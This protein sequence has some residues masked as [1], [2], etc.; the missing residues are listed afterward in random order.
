V[1]FI[2]R[3]GRNKGKERSKSKKER[4]TLLFFSNHINR[5]S[6][7]LF[8]TASHIVIGLFLNFAE[9]TESDDRPNQQEDKTRQDKTTV[10]EQDKL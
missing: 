5:Y 8:F 7:Q 10:Q 9:T 6:K 4:K 1:H 2:A 3:Q